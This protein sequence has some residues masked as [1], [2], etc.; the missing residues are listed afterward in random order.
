VLLEPVLRDVLLVPVG[1]VE[2]GRDVDDDTGLLEVGDAVGRGFG[3]GFAGASAGFF[4]TGS[5]VSSGLSVLV[6]NSSA[7]PSSLHRSIAHPNFARLP[8]WAGKQI[9]RAGFGEISPRTFATLHRNLLCAGAE[10]NHLQPIQE[11]SIQSE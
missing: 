9:Q 10:Q 6:S 5:V 2:E 11:Y 8:A 4:F 7:I 3:E 1:R